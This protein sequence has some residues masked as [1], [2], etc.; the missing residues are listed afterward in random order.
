[1]ARDFTCSL[2]VSRIGKGLKTNDLKAPFEKF[3]RIKDVYIPLDFHTK[4]SRGFGYVE[5][6]NRDDAEAAYDSRKDIIVLGKPVAIEF[7]R[8]QRKS[9]REMRPK[10]QPQPQL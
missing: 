2:H 5:Y 4:E 8:G 6:Y 10:P 3:G 7:A 9:S 1:M